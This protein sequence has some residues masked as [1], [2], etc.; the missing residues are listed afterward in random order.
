MKLFFRVLILLMFLTP[1]AYGASIIR[2]SEIED[3]LQSISRPIFK[4]ADLTP[5]NIR[6]YIVNDPQINAFVSGGQ[7]IFLNTGLIRQSDS[8]EMLIGV[9][10][11]ETGHISGGHLLLNTDEIKGATIKSTLGYILGIAAAAA[12]SPGAGQAIAAGGIHVAQ[13]QYLKH[14]RT[15]EEAADQAALTYLD[16]IG[17]SAEGL[18]QLLTVLYN[19]QSVL[20]GELNPYTLTHPLHRERISHIEN[21]LKNSP[22]ANRKIPVRTLEQFA[23]AIAKLD[24]FLDTPEQ[25]LQRFPPENTQTN[26]RYARAIAYYKIPDLAKSLNE[27]DTLIRQSPED[28]YFNELKGQILFENG[29]V[30]E[31]I[32]FYEKARYLLPDDALLKIQLATAQIASQQEDMRESAINNL[33][34]A[35]HQDKDNLFAWRQLAIAYG[36]GGQLGMSNL[37]LAEEALRLGNKEDVKKFVKL[38]REHVK[39]GSPADLRLNDISASIENGI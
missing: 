34:Q 7:N 17:Y 19:K 35:L 9:I 6:V 21:H 16:K 13:R 5:E 31:S 11:H 38:A 18:R 32:V 20:V 4:A 27:I 14:T 15:Q 26:A 1:Q 33:Q 36:R 25:T 30:V 28:P 3:V 39:T 24:A 23:R 22:Y 12:G 8:P 29:R 10:A 37:A 2:D